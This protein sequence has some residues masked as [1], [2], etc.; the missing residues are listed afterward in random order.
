MYNILG[1]CLVSRAD[2]SSLVAYLEAFC[3]YVRDCKSSAVWGK[4]TVEMLFPRLWLCT[5]LIPDQ[6]PADS[7][8]EFSRHSLKASVGEQQEPPPAGEHRSCTKLARTAPCIGTIRTAMPKAGTKNEDSS[9]LFATPL[10]T[11][12]PRRTPTV[13]TKIARC[14]STD[15]FCGIKNRACL[16]AQLWQP[17]P[18]YLSTLSSWAALCLEADTCAHQYGCKQ[19]CWWED[20]VWEPK[21]HLL[22]KPEWL[23]FRT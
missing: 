1:Y 22:S 16:P 3:V 19:L 15:F 6:T 18:T 12:C 23:P 17:M 10:W 20:S 7:D 8:L 11:L 2:S 9:C 13:I 21:L 5:W 4:S 14:D